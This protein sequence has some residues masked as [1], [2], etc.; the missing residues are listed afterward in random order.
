MEP[1]EIDDEEYVS[2][3]GSRQTGSPGFLNQPRQVD[4]DGLSVTLGKLTPEEARRYVRRGGKIGRDDGVRHARVGDLRRQGMLV[5]NTP[6][7]ENPDHASISRPGK[8]PGEWSVEDQGTYDT[9]YGVP[10][11]HEETEEGR[12]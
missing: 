6:S 12:E 5:T 4:V 9:C 1:R 7:R 8:G 3:Y 11:W 2:Q 10:E